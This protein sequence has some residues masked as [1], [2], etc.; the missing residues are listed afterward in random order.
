M[1]S[2]GVRA[3]TSAKPEIVGPCTDGSFG[4]DLVTY[5]RSKI[6]ILTATREKDGATGIRIYLLGTTKQYDSSGT[7]E[8]KTRRSE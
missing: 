8:G 5:I 2:S 6:A 3:S 4:I 7:R 1:I